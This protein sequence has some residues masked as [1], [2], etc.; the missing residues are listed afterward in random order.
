MAHLGRQREVDNEKDAWDKLQIIGALLIPVSIAFVGGYFS[1]VMASAETKLESERFRFESEINES[2]SRINQAGLVATFIEPLFSDN[3]ARQRLAIDAV[4]IALPEKGPELVKSLQANGNSAEIQS[5]AADSLFR[6][7]ADALD[8][9]FSDTQSRRRVGYQNLFSAY[10]QD[11]SIVPELIER[12]KSTADNLDAVF[13]TL[14][15]LSHMN[16]DLLKPYTDMISAF[17]EDVRSNG[18]RTE[19]RVQK[20]LSRLG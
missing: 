8:D 13:N 14:V 5:Y 16:A 20:L 4:L 6:F 17:A 1:Y 3:P 11:G 18:D 12:A 9:F 19:E 7:K 10:S 2:N 15:F